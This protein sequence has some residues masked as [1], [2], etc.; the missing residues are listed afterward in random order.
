MGLPFVSARGYRGQSLATA[1]G[2]GGGGGEE[3]DGFNVG[4]LDTTSNL[5][6]RTG[7]AQGFI[8]FNTTTS[9]LYVAI[10]TDNK[11]NITK[12]DQD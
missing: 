2:G 11:W 5:A 7:D 6:S 8:A 4:T 10:G 3:E 9:E 1:A 12:A